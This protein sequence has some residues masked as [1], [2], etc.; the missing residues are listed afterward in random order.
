MLTFSS[1]TWAVESIQPE[2]QEP[3]KIELAMGKSFV[4]PIPESVKKSDHIRVTI[5]APEIADFLFIPKVNRKNRVRNIYIKGLKPGVTNLTLWKNG[6]MFR[7]YDVEVTFDI[8]LLKQRLHDIIPEEKDIRVFASTDGITLSG[9]IS[10]TCLKWPG[11]NKS[12]WKSK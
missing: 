6:S 5:A 3:G 1:N 2:I 8:S 12:C 11:A 10:T 9:T 4:L 7:L